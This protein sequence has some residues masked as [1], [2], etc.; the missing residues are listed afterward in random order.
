MRGAR[1]RRSSAQSQRLSPS[2]AKRSARR[3]HR[4]SPNCPIHGSKAKVAAAAAARTKRVAPPSSPH[5]TPCMFTRI[6]NFIVAKTVG[7]GSR[8]SNSSNSAFMNWQRLVGCV[9]CNGRPRLSQRAKMEIGFII[10]HLRLIA[11]ERDDN[12]VMVFFNSIRSTT[13]DEELRPMASYHDDLNSGLVDKTKET[14]TTGIIQADDDVYGHSQRLLVI[15]SLPPSFLQSPD[16]EVVHQ[17]AS[18][19][20]HPSISQLCFIDRNQRY[21]SPRM[22]SNQPPPPW[23]IPLV[24]QPSFASTKKPPSK[25]R[26]TRAPHCSIESTTPLQNVK[27]IEES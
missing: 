1:R 18:S 19:L 4:V 2:I 27:P 23:F 17:P 24:F 9:D 14:R 22:L 8:G 12:G 6:M 10:H 3:I 15:L 11:Q 7:Y 5:S 25:S 21:R 20:Q 16:H 13:S 26:M